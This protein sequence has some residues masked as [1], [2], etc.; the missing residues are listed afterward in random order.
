MKK[1]T[2]S[3]LHE[4][5]QY[6][7]SLLT[8][9]AKENQFQQLF[10]T[11]PYIFSRSL[12]L[13]IEPTDIVPLGRPGISEPDFIFYPKKRNQLY[14]HGVIEL[15]RPSTKLITTPRKDL[16]ILSR[17]AA[18]AVSQ[19]YNFS[20]INNSELYTNP[21]QNLIIGNN[22]YVFIIAGLSEELYS[23]TRTPNF[24]EEL[25]KLVPPGCSIIPYDVLLEMYSSGIPP[26]SYILRP[27][28]QK[29]EK[30][31]SHLLELIKLNEDHTQLNDETVDLW[32]S[33]E[34]IWR[35]L[36]YDGRRFPA[37]RIIN[38]KRWCIENT[39]ILATES[40]NNYDFAHATH[41]L[42]TIISKSVQ[43][44]QSLKRIRESGMKIS[45]LGQNL[46]QS[47]M[48]ILIE[49]SDRCNKYNISTTFIYPHDSADA[50]FLQAVGIDN[51]RKL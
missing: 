27:L 13:Q 9:K 50:E 41:Y 38:R 6:F 48:T 16:I 34:N 23:K 25:N 10:T 4:A 36:I 49:A 19:S 33:I 44:H 5:R 35:E 39:D 21:Q 37:R 26:L 43:I 22:S 11:H 28:I 45:N 14:S 30:K 18:T 51:L 32:T 12:P 42:R 17:D 47:Q 3:E 8:K 1:P 31:I 2:V 40:P 20:V 24:L 46:T 29:K 15:K 7:E